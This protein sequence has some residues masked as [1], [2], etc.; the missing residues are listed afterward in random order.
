MADNKPVIVLTRPWPKPV[1]AA[2]R[3]DYRLALAHPPSAKRI[4]S[5]L[6]GAAAFCPTFSDPVNGEL[7]ARFPETVKLIASYGVGV[8]HIDL[9]AAARKGL[10]VTNTPEVVSED[11]ADLAIGLIIAVMRGFSRGEALVRAGRWRGTGTEGFLG[12][13]VSGKTLGI[14]GLGRI[15]RLVARRAAAFGMKI[16]YHGKNRKPEA[17]KETGAGFCG[18]LGD[19]V[20][21]CDVVSLHCP[22][23]DETRHLVDAAL[24]EKFKPGS[25]LINTGRGALVDEAALVAALETGPLAGAGL[26]VYEFEPRL[27]D[28]L[29]AL[30]NVTLLPHL[31]TATEETR[32]AMGFRVKENLDLFFAGK[33]VRDPVA[34]P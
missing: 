7:I 26:D 15:G 5:A 4:L 16:L 29:E 25:F 1:L 6:E 24:L 27:A 17:E 23:T 20:G 32:I 13:K 21:R 11:T 28:G 33:P 2:L 8:D 3:G 30:D 31:G 10:V 19:L 22:L 12:R 14:V 34:A 9:A 18:A